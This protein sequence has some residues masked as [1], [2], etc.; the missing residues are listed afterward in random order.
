MPHTIP[1][2]DRVLRQLIALWRDPGAPLP[3]LDIDLVGQATP[4]ALE[5]LAAYRR[6]LGHAYARDLVEGTLEASPNVV[7]FPANRN[8]RLVAFPGPG[9]AA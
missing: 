1:I 6:L 5:E 8:A 4:A 2:T 7:R 3:D 9:G